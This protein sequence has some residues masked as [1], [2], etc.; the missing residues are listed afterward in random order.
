MVQWLRLYPSNAGAGG[1]IPGGET[2]I[3]YVAWL[4]KCKKKIIFGKRI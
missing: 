3:P 4:K 2:K 1:S